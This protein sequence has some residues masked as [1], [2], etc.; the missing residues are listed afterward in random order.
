MI[1]TKDAAMPKGFTCEACGTTGHQVLR[2]IASGDDRRK[3]GAMVCDA[4]RPSDVVIE[5][6]QDFDPD[7]VAALKRRADRLRHSVH[8]SAV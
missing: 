1:A 2:R 6:S 5:V 3:D 7:F 4:C 8:R